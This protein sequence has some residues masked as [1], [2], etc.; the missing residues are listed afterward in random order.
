MKHDY[1]NDDSP[2]IIDLNDWILLNHPNVYQATKHIGNTTI[3]MNIWR[4]IWEQN[5]KPEIRS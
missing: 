5:G 2:D 4:K 1:E 3:L